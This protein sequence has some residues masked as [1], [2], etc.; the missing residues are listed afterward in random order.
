MV[1]QPDSLSDKA[2]V[3]EHKVCNKHKTDDKKEDKEAHHTFTEW[4]PTG[5]Q[6]CITSWTPL[7]DNPDV[8]QPEEPT[9]PTTDDN[10][11][12]KEANHTFTEWIPT[13]GQ[14]LITSWTPVVE[15]LEV[16]NTAG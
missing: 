12:D 7:S 10:K 8:L 13:G 5:R 14:N 4:I 11:E 15:F 3:L 16:L 9:E 1:R 2:N 6:D